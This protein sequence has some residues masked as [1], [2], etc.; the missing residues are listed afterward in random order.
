MLM[1]IGDIQ[2][3]T[4]KIISV[5]VETINREY[6]VVIELPDRTERLP[7]RYATKGLAEAGMHR[8]A[9]KINRFEGI[10]KC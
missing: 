10:D 1:L 3:N 6:A 7:E 4:R 9:Y 8:I 5:F 2:L